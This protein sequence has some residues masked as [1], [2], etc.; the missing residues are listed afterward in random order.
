MVCCPG[1]LGGGCCPEA[2]PLCSGTN[3]CNEG[4]PSSFTPDHEPATVPRWHPEAS[5]R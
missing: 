4:V 5:A 2:M 3:R 1:S